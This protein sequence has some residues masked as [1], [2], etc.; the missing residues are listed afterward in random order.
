VAV[1]HGYQARAAAWG[2]RCRVAHRGGRGKR[3]REREGSERGRLADGPARRVGPSWPWGGWYD[4]WAR[5]GK[6]KERKGKENRINSNLKLK[7]QIYS[8]FIRS[9]HNLHEL[10]IFEIKYGWKEFET[11]DNFSYINIL[12]FDMDFELKFRKFSRSRKQEK[13]DWKFLELGFWW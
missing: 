10:Q 6:R 5:A 4:R 7:L 11:R 12:G 8:N 3:E 1:A 9:K 2:W 13:I